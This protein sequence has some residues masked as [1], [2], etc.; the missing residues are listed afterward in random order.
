M[1][2]WMENLPAE[3]KDAPFLRATAE[4]PRDIAQVVA[5]LNDAAQHMGNSIRIPGPD[6]GDEA[7][8]QFRQRAVDKVPGLMVI[9]NQDDAESMASVFRTMGMPEEA[10]GYRL[11]EIEGLEMSDEQAGALRAAAHG[12]NLTQKQFEAMVATQHEQGKAALDGQNAA[13]QE[14]LNALKGEWGAAY[15]TRVGEVKAI[16]Q[17]IDAPQHI[18][19]MA[20]AGTLQ[21]SELKMFYAIADMVGTEGSE[22]G[23]QP[24]QSKTVMTPAQAEAEM[25]EIENRADDPL[26]NVMHPDH[27][28]LSKRMV[29]LMMLANPDSSTDSLRTSYGS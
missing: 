23:D 3:L 14:G 24:N 27:E 17:K 28:R 19:D 12:L 18:I 22:I 5:D 15:D 6:A 1:S 16:L 20:E 11:P 10:S 7:M 4:G 21:A 8:V 25:T 2:D 9:P 29:E 13:L 26:G